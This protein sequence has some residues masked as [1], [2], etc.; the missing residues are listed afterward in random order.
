ML[1][2]PAKLK[3]IDQ[4]RLQNNVWLKRRKS[5]RRKKSQSVGTTEKS[6]TGGTSAQS[7]TERRENRSRKTIE[8]TLYGYT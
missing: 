8:M 3:A 1:L 7:P 5:K 2:L 4:T 6:A